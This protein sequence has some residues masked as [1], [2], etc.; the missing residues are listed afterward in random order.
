MGWNA[1]RLEVHGRISNHYSP[2]DDKDRAD[3]EEFVDRVK[4]IAKEHRYEALS[5]YVRSES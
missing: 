5:L 1:A 4:A 3:W 2:Q